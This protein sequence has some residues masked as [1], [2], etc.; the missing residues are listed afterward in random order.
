MLVTNYRPI[1][2]QN[3]VLKIFDATMHAELKLF[4]DE[5]NI[6]APTQG[7]FRDERGTMEQLQIYQHL[8]DQHPTMCCAFLDIRKAYDT[9]WRK[10]L[11]HKLRYKYQMDEGLVS[12]Y[13]EM[14]HNTRSAI[15]TT[16]KIGRSF[17]TTG[18]LLQGAL[19][20][21][22]LFNLYINGLA[23]RLN[24]TSIGYNIP[25]IPFKL[26]NLLF[27][28]DIVLVAPTHKHLENLLKICLEYAK[29]WKLTFNPLKS[30]IIQHNTCV[31][32]YDTDNPYTFILHEATLIKFAAIFV[33]EGANSFY[34]GI[35]IANNGP[36]LETFL[37]QK[38]AV[39]KDK[40]NQLE[41]FCLMIDADFH[42]RYVLY[43]T[44]LRSRLEY[45]AQVLKIPG[46]MLYK[47]RTFQH[48][49]IVRLFHLDP[50]TSLTI[51]EISTGIESIDC[52]LA[53]L[54]SNYIHKLQNCNKK[55]LN[56]AKEVLHI[57]I[58]ENKIQR[59][60]GAPV[61][62][63]TLWS[64]VQHDHAHWGIS[65][66][67]F[68]PK[69]PDKSPNIV[70]KEL[71]HITKEVFDKK[72]LE[73]TQE[74][75]H[76]QRTIASNEI[77]ALQHTN[78]IELWD[79][80]LTISPE[81]AYM[82]LT[83]ADIR[84]V[85]TSIFAGYRPHHAK[86]TQSDHTC[87]MCKTSSFHGIAFHKL[88]FCKSVKS[89]R[90]NILRS[91]I[92]EATFFCDK[93]LTIKPSTPVQRVI[94]LIKH[95]LINV[96][97]NIIQKGK[98][99][100]VSRLIH[101][102]FNSFEMY[103]HGTNVHPENPSFILARMIRRMCLGHLVTLS[104]AIRSRAVHQVEKWKTIFFKHDHHHIAEEDLKKGK[105]LCRVRD[106]KGQMNFMNIRDLIDSL[107]FSL[108]LQYDIGLGSASTRT[109]NQ[110]KRAQNYTR[111]RW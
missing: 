69:N 99:T 25:N 102:L 39:C 55:K 28:D 106:N 26:N 61:K 5:N 13:E 48:D 77:P 68:N 60:Y 47:L 18:G 44:L 96:L 40:L 17:L 36:A 52:R 16:S 27:A 20:S 58:H 41:S 11:F 4:V 9:V 105:I 23:E 109:N 33:P 66:M 29:E 21:P 93:F 90:M 35:P 82:P 32:K 56:I 19:S 7:G 86:Y 63:Y 100:K 15:K 42:L 14:Y 75:I 1:A 94:T 57:E 34:L 30:K 51:A 73:L 3:T 74:I 2:L 53:I 6:I 65:A 84:R 87:N 78:P 110:I 95:D 91:I 98:V 76:N 45:A 24:N 71:K 64:R 54:R 46:N 67:D 22:L 72:D 107:P 80:N 89:L 79:G 37:N 70:L 103:L 104:E 111:R 10:G 97:K 59:A 50:H 12:M 108:I 31:T 8:Y 92:R 85:T 38:L 81:F 83:F 62:P 88:F 49:A 43:K 101:T